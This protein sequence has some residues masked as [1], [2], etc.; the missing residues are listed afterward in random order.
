VFIFYTV[1]GSACSNTIN[2]VSTRVEVKGGNAV[3]R[4]SAVPDHPD[5]TYLCKLNNGGYKP[6]ECLISQCKNL[7]HTACT[8]IEVSIKEH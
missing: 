8:I 1:H 7:M 4:F 3:V 6:C 5:V 2:S